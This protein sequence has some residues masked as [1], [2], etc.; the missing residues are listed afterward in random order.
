MDAGDVLRRFGEPVDPALA[1]LPG[2]GVDPP[3]RGRGVL[4]RQLPRRHGERD[5]I[6]G[7]LRWRAMWSSSQLAATSSPRPSRRRSG[8]WPWPGDRSHDRGGAPRCRSR[9]RTRRRAR[10]RG[11]G[12]RE[13]RRRALSRSSLAGLSLEEVGL[14][15]LLGPP[16]DAK[17]LYLERPE[18]DRGLQAE[19]RNP[20]RDPPRR[21]GRLEQPDD[22]VPPVL[23]PLEG[24]DLDGLA[25]DGDP[26][27]RTLL[28]ARRK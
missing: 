28:S 19:G 15:E 16:V 9:R 22:G 8:T 26:R 11:S 14:D 4:G 10:G 25:F 27:L 12:L 18:P 7:S 3:G 17:R 2:H 6:E 13:R 24:R 20:D 23:G 5:D 21:P 1:V